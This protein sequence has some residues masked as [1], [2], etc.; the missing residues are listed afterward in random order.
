L[1]FG[2]CEGLCAALGRG[3]LAVRANI[4]PLIHIF[5]FLQNASLLPLDAVAVDLDLDTHTENQ[6]QD[7]EFQDADADAFKMNFKM[8]VL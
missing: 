3:L 4:R 8:Q 6:M 5:D 2:C 7:D 1:S